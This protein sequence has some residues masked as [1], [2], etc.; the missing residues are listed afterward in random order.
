MF[1]DILLYF[2]NFLDD[3][4]ALYNLQVF[5]QLYPL[6]FKTQEVQNYY[7]AILS[8]K[9]ESQTEELF[10]VFR[11]LI[12]TKESSSRV[13]SQF[14]INKY[15]IDRAIVDNSGIIG[16]ELKPLIKLQNKKIIL[17]NLNDILSDTKVQEQ[18]QHYLLH[19]KM[20]YLIL[21]NLFEV[22]VFTRW[23]YSINKIEPQIKL[24][25][26][27]FAKEYC[28]AKRLKDLLA[29]YF[30]DY[31]ILELDQHFF[32][33]LKEYW[34]RIDKLISDK[35][36]KIKF[37]NTLMM[38]RLLEDVGAL[39]FGTV[40]GEW[41]RAKYYHGTKAENTIKTFIGNF[42]VDT[43]YEYYDTELL[44]WEIDN[45]I[46]NYKT[47]LNEI[48]VSIGEILGYEGFEK[49]FFKGLKFYD[50]N[51]INEDVFGKAYESFLAELRKET[52]IFYTPAFI[53][54]YIAQ[55]TIADKFEKIY[56][57]V[58]LLINSIETEPPEKLYSKAKEI[59]KQLN[60]ITILD[61][62]CGSGSFLV[63]VLKIIHFYYKKFLLIFAVK[64]KF[65][66]DLNSESGVA[67]FNNNEILEKI[68]IL[69]KIKK[70]I[71]ESDDDNIYDFLKNMVKRH[72]FGVDI[73][74]AALD[75]AKLNIWKELIKLEPDQYL[76][77]N[78]RQ[79][80]HRYVFP[81]L[82]NN[83]KNMDSILSTFDDW[84]KQFPEVFNKG[85]FSIVIGNPPYVR[86]ENID[87][88]VR[89]SLREVYPGLFLGHIDIYTAFIRRAVDLLK[90]EGILGFIISNKWMR[91]KYGQP[92]RKIF[93]NEG[94]ILELIDFSG[95]KVFKD[96]TV[97]TA[98]VL[99]RKGNKTETEFLSCIVSN[100]FENYIKEGK[101][102]KDYVN[103]KGLKI[104]INSLSEDSFLLLTKEEYELKK[105]IERIGKPLKDWDVK[106]YIGILTGYNE[107]FII[108]TKTRD[109]ILS[110][111]KTETERK[112]TEEFIK[113][114]LRGRD[115]DRYCYKWNNQW[116]IIIPAG[117][118][119][120]ENKKGLD[121]EEFFKE[122]LPSLYS[123]LKLFSGKAKG[124]RKGLIDRENQ[125]DYWW[126][127][128]PC[129]YYSEF[130]KE[131]I[132][133][134]RVTQ[135]F[136][137]CLAPEGLYILDSMA[138][139]IGNN[140]KYLIALLN[141][142]LINFYIKT[143]V[144]QYADTGFLL[145]NQYVEKIPI[146]PITKENQLIVSQIE[147][148]VDR[149]LALK[150]K[151]CSVDTSQLETEID[152]F[153]FKLYD[154]TQEEIDLVKKLNNRKGDED[155]KERF[156]MAK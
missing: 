94:D 36:E 122:T 120:K 34:Q 137:F 79:Y 140:A 19:P 32:N 15:S 98:V 105:K 90:N 39:P 42:I 110:G 41:E 156:N 133:W 69:R 56:R 64:N 151:N 7:Q 100:D 51:T 73:D 12:T 88:S 131:K 109:K 106:I 75:I 28:K 13:I 126:E 125:G 129:D 22:F 117:W 9:P 113:P 46:K 33:D 52:G 107:A 24:S 119:N 72:I 103:D 4:E 97:D 3:L 57:E 59:Y 21:T 37:I 101:K 154:L 130:E 134:Q 23:N 68:K 14:K 124:R 142:K 16:I 11:N 27:D 153:V 43:L 61:P 132:V 17:T 2:K 145:S 45:F 148:L 20:R 26:L 116:I 58:N 54:E 50:F 65:Y 77:E 85:G 147:S 92:L 128:R 40:E 78:V 60:S 95:Y 76:I 82:T 66:A 48:L 53:T 35:K 136:S 135:K 29:K 1:Q 25:F 83:F 38:I 155:N 18:L 89:D 10:N 67:L 93:I 47:K 150:Q 91:A 115:I 31:P 104:S 102:L 81:D 144:H 141:S 5:Q 80:G 71:F 139:L 118:T 86:G 152:N 99:F 149:I 123:Y 108:D 55:K 96:A 44:N 70:L 62:A 87:E 112:M 6:T 84:E 143:Y 121:P 30:K 111:C 127:L 63:K 146:P 74:P 114:V 138:F 8:A 49:V